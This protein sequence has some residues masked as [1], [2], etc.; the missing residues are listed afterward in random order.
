[1]VEFGSYFGKHK[2]LKPIKGVRFFPEFPIHFKVGNG[3]I[4]S[5]GH[6]AT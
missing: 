3:T 4:D 6:Q 5:G 2:A 1:M